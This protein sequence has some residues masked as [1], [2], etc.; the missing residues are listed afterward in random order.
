[1]IRRKCIEESKKRIFTTDD[2]AT[3][4]NEMVVPPGLEPGTFSVLARNHDQLDH[5]TLRCSNHS[6]STYIWALIVSSKS[7]FHD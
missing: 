5:G 7:S 6:D 3:A 1:M 4:K 2:E